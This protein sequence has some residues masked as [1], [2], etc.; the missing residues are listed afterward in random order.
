MNQ[1]SAWRNASGLLV[2]LGALVVPPVHA[3]PPVCAPGA[4]PITLTGAVKVSQEKTYRLL[5]FDVLEGT[6]R[7][8]VGYRWDDNPGLPSTPLTATTLDL[9]LWDHDGTRGVRAFRGWSGSRQGRLDLDQPPVFVEPD[10]AERGYTPGAV[11][12][13]LWHVEIGIAAV[14]P[15]G[16]TYEVRIACK[17]AQGTRPAN[18]RVDPRHIARFEP[19]WY[20]GD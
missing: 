10:V 16:A 4:A 12:P 14:A 6:G 15:Q 20:H 1:H 7:V 18:D 9:G 19:G 2:L 3:A 8:E 13:G 11:R 17:A 5:P